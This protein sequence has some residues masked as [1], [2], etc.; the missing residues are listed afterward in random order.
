[1]DVAYRIEPDGK[2]DAKNQV[3]LNQLTFGEKVA[4]PMPPSC[5]RCW[6]WPC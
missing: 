4:S 6:R 1:M 5:R 2:L 3:I